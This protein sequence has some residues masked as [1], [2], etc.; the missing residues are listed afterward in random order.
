MSK[1]KDTKPA[2]GAT[3]TETP[4]TPTEPETKPAPSPAPD[5]TDLDGNPIPDEAEVS[6]RKEH[7]KGSAI[8]IEAILKSGETRWFGDREFRDEIVQFRIDEAETS[9]AEAEAKAAEE[10]AKKPIPTRGPTAKRMVC[11]NPGCG[12]TGPLAEMKVDPT[13][14]KPHYCPKCGRSNTIREAE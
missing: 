10:D 12:W 11:D 14:K 7:V 5:E 4:V 6:E 3:P 8:V 2:A 13:L 9:K 1:D